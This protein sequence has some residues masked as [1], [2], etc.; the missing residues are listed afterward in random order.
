MFVVLVF[1]GPRVAGVLWWLVQPTRW[2]AAFS[3]NL[4]WPILG[5]IFVPWM[6]LMYILVAPGGITGFDWVWLGLALVGDIAGYTGG[7]KN[8]GSVPMMGGSSTPS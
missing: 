3:G 8:R 7:F 6:T 2:S 1:L 4:I 5:L